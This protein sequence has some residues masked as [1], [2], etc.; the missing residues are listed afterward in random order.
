MDQVFR[1][2]VTVHDTSDGAIL[3]GFG[4]TGGNRFFRVQEYHDD[5]LEKV[6]WHKESAYPGNVLS[7]IGEEAFYR[8]QV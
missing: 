1:P 8:N 5:L 7:I 2:E 3:T 4:N 6:S